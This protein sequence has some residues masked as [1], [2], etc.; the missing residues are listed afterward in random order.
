MYFNEER[1]KFMLL[2][3]IYHRESKRFIIN[4]LISK[5]IIIY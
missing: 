1:M 4:D 2:K 5:T 3:L